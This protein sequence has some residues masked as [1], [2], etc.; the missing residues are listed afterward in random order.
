MLIVVMILVCRF[1]FTGPGLL[2]EFSNN[3]CR[4][5]LFLNFVRQV[6]VLLVISITMNNE[7]HSQISGKG[8]ECQ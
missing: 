6:I 2:W 4:I 1:D 7:E 8:K 3:L 5:G